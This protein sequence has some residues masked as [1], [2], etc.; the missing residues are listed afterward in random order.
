MCRDAPGALLFQASQSSLDELYELLMA[1]LPERGG[2]H[3]G[4]RAAGL[5]LRSEPRG[6]R[7]LFT[8]PGRGTKDVRT[9]FPARGRNADGQGSGLRVAPCKPPGHGS[10]SHL[11]VPFV[12]PRSARS[13]VSFAQGSGGFSE[14]EGP[15]EWIACTGR[16]EGGA[17]GSGAAILT[18][19]GLHGARGC[20]RDQTLRVK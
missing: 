19:T 16:A 8:G 4:A 13:T 12:R 2:P 6:S 18:V 3:Q 14:G 10:S 1:F 20:R 17:L 7:L 5:P 11:A 15:A 9:P